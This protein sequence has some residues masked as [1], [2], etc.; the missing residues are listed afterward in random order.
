MRHQ[1]ENISV[2]TLLRA[3]L[4]RLACQERHYVRV[5]TY[6]RAASINLNAY[7]D[8][9]ACARAH[10]HI[11]RTHTSYRSVRAGATYVQLDT[12]IK[13]FR[14]SHRVLGLTSSNS[15]ICRYR[16]HLVH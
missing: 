12:L 8:A 14:V 1:K 15:L 4:S 9:R 2:S 13:S 7:R 10:A 11:G 16:D 5:Y 6:M 3:L